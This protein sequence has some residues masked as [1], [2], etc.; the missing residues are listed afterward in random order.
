M[1]RLLTLMLVAVAALAQAQ[2]G[3]QIDRILQSHYDPS[4]TTNFQFCVADSSL[5]TLFPGSTLDDVSAS[6]TLTSPDGA[7]GGVGAE[8]ILYITTVGSGTGQTVTE[9]KVT[10]AASADSI[11]VGASTTYTGSTTTIQWRNIT[12]GTT[13]DAGWFPVRGHS[14]KTVQVNVTTLGSSSLTIQVQGRLN[15]MRGVAGWT[16]LQP[17][18]ITA[19][20]SYGWP[21]LEDV[22][23]MRVGAKVGSD[24]TNVVK[25]AY[26][27]SNA[28]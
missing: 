13:A 9:R 21:I 27:A 17:T 1:R 5:N 23:E 10:A 25:I 28:Q 3:S 22:A 7:F 24:S 4:D 20:G 12:C 14:N 2:S 15:S 19:T 8:D 6:T 16:L 26:G 18:N 11:T